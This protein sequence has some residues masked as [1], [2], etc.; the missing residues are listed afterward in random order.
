MKNDIEEL[1][2]NN[3]KSINTEIITLMK[4]ITKQ[5]KRKHILKK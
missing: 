3:D 2:I 1:K 5:D 4:K